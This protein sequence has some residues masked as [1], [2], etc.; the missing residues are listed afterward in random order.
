MNPYHASNGRIRA[1]TESNANTREGSILQGDEFTLGFWT[2]TDD[3][4]IDAWSHTTFDGAPIN[5]TFAD[6][7]A[8]VDAFATRPEPA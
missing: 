3:G 7:Q 5:G 8:V 2:R 1:R 4:L 6:L